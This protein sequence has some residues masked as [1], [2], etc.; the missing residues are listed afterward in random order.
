MRSLICQEFCSRSSSS[1]WSL[2]QLFPLDGSG[3]LRGQIPEDAVDALDLMGD[4]LDNAAHH[5]EVKLRHL[6][7][8]GIGNRAVNGLVRHRIRGR[9][10]RGPACEGVAR[11]RRDCREREALVV[12]LREGPCRVASN[13]AAV[14]VEGD[15][16]EVDSLRTGSQFEVGGTDNGLLSCIGGFTVQVQVAGDGHVLRFSARICGRHVISIVAEGNF[17][18]SLRC[19]GGNGIVQFGGSCDG[20]HAFAHVGTGAGHHAA[21]LTCEAEYQSHF[22]LTAGLQTFDSLGARGD[23]VGSEVNDQALLAGLLYK[24]LGPDGIQ[25]F[26]VRSVI[27]LDGKGV[28]RTGG[29]EFIILSVNI[30]R[31]AFDRKLSNLHYGAEKHGLRIAVGSC[32][33]D[34]SLDPK[35]TFRSADERMYS[36]KMAYYDKNPGLKRH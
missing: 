32:W 26:L 6:C 17:D 4:A 3:G 21:A 23:F 36:D 30:D 18:P 22:V 11:P 10:G 16:L 27:P 14:A 5:T 13:V 19:G 25:V 33:C 35:E 20:H 28:F 31:E 8:H 12:R 9:L 29:D 1:L 34:G 24:R 2:P 15:V 7:G